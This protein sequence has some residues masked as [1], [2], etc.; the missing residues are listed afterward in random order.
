MDP[1]T[2]ALL[3]V[4]GT[5]PAEY[6]LGELEVHRGA[7]RKYR[8]GLKARHSSQA[9]QPLLQWH[10]RTFTTKSAR[11]RD[12]AAESQ[13]C[14][15]ITAQTWL[16]LAAKTIQHE[17][18]QQPPSRVTTGVRLAAPAPGSL[19]EPGVGGAERLREGCGGAREGAG[20]KKGSLGKRA[21]RERA[22][23]LREELVKAF[24]GALELQ[25]GTLAELLRA[26]KATE[27]EMADEAM[28]RYMNKGT[29]NTSQARKKIKRARE[30]DLR[31]RAVE[32]AADEFRADS[33]EYF[34]TVLRDAQKAISAAAALE[35]VSVFF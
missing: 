13:A 29:Y 26:W 1:D 17:A 7:P 32:A 16:D 24:P 22:T 6:E 8:I 35:D 31:A 11:G 18:I 12:R 27:P 28:K 15:T 2:D 25:A 34:D 30:A 9:G 21:R 33:I 3:H 14:R 10:S 19:Q 23:M 4:K 5:L 20:R